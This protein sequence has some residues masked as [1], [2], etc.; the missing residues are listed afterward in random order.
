M[1]SV[2]YMTVERWN[3]PKGKIEYV[4]SF[5]TE[6]FRAKL[7]PLWQDHAVLEPLLVNDNANPSPNGWEMHHDMHKICSSQLDLFLE[8]QKHEQRYMHFRIL[9]NE[10]D[11]GK[12]CQCKNILLSR[13]ELRKEGVQSCAFYENGNTVA[14]SFS[15]FLKPQYSTLKS[16]S[17]NEH[18]GCP[19][20]ISITREEMPKWS[21]FIPYALLLPIAKINTRF[22]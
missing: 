4:C 1:P 22:E 5:K 3:R 7:H 19:W 8:R 10:M 20:N 15:R 12:D 11:I 6:K 9:K 21:P 2:I 16:S 17:L 14:Y 18:R 13:K